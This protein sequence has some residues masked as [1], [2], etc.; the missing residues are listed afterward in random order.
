MFWFDALCYVGFLIDCFSLA[1]WFAFWLGSRRLEAVMRHDKG[2]S[3]GRGSALLIENNQWIL[4]SL[5]PIK[6]FSK[7]LILC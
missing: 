7:L 6:R 1:F 4:L 3:E 2:F 5:C